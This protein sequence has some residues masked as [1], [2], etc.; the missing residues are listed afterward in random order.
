MFTSRRTIFYQIVNVISFT[1]TIIANFLSNI[2]SFEGK[3][4]GGIS[5]SYPN[6]FTPAGYVFSIWG[7]IYTLLLIFTFYQ[8]LPEQR[9]DP[10]IPKISYF[11]ILSN[12]ANTSWLFLWLSEQIVLS[13]IPMFVLLGSLIAIYL[14]LQ[15]GLSNASLKERLLVNLPFS[16]Y[17]GWIT[18][19]TIA[20]VAA[21]LV[22]VN[23]D[24]WGI[25]AVIW[26]II[27]IALAMIVNLAVIATRGEIAY[28]L[29][30][31]WALVGIIVKQI[32]D[33][34]IASTAGVGVAIIIIALIVK[35][36]RDYRFK[37]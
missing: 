35:V 23:W 33:Q 14:R 32:E 34:I 27:M 6:L 30:I 4:V 3:N 5:D 17:L 25:S 8:A 28:S 29:V 22:A 15:I 24:G 12:I 21:A 36:I 16:V 13:L 9:D 31:I 2:F 7:V 37:S 10:F 18:V 11:F 20:N 1:I 19:A 26:T